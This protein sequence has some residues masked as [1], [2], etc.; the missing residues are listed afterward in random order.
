LRVAAL[1]VVAGHHE[2]VHGG[3]EQL[4][5]PADHVEPVG[6][7]HLEIDDREVGRCLLRLVEG[8]RAVVSRH[9]LITGA[10]EAGRHLAADHHV[11]IDHQDAYTSGGG[12]TRRGR[13][14]GHRC[15]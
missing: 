3:T 14:A 12:F 5:E 2:D 15:C 7:G 1:V 11:V 9:H 4:L 13:I 8:A 6:A 10:R